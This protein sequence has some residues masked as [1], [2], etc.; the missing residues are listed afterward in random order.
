MTIHISK[1]MGKELKE[2]L[3][4]NYFSICWELHCQ[5]TIAFKNT[6]SN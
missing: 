6:V 1:I 3:K 4:K 5:N 2:F